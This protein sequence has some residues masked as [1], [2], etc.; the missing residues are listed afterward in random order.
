[1]KVS[2][3]SVW[4]IGRVSLIWDQSHSSKA[5]NLERSAVVMIISDVHSTS[6][7]KI[8]L[9]PLPEILALLGTYCS[10]LLGSIV[11]CSPRPS[12]HPYYWWIERYKNELSTHSENLASCLHSEWVCKTSKPTLLFREM[13]M[14]LHD[15]YMISL[16]PFHHFSLHLSC[17]SLTSPS[18]SL[19]SLSL[20]PP[21][22]LSLSLT[23]PSTSFDSLV[24]S[25][26]SSF[27]LFLCIPSPS[28]Y[29][30]SPPP[31]LLPPAPPGQVDNT[32]VRSENLSLR[33][34]RLTW[35]APED[36]N[37]PITNYWITYCISITASINDTCVRST[38]IP[39]FDSSE[40]P[41]VDL[42]DINPERRYRITIWAENAAGMG[43]ESPPYFFDS[44]SAGGCW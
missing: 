24:L 20:L 17:L 29:I 44:A 8:A 28:L 30:L 4:I 37:A 32:T 22:L 38:T 23:S 3:V 26:T 36:N 18:T 9:P 15:I 33:R 11:P 1:M 19:D 41:M 5:A 14:F 31:L 12:P 6:V 34:T 21:P 25:L 39:I 13:W 40:K 2:G 10:K 27:F 42:T 7:Y 35:E 16:L 43:P